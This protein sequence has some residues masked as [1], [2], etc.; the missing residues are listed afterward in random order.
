MSTENEWHSEADARRFEEA[1][2]AKVEM[3]TD[4]A[5]CWPWKG[6]IN[7]KGYGVVKFKGRQYRAH[8]VVYEL[9]NGPISEGLVL[10]HRCSNRRCCNPSHLE[11]V[12]DRENILRGESF[13][14][15]RARGQ[16]Q[17]DE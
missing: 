3:T 2:W 11:P 9:V 10:D 14:G 4:D 8:R 13:S 1:V 16:E 6:T 7:A 12:T 5:E 17:Y 15:R